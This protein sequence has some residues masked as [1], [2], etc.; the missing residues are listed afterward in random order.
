MDDN[1]PNNPPAFPTRTSGEDPARPDL[2]GMELRDYFAAKALNGTADMGVNHEDETA[3]R[4]YKIA[5]AMLKER[6]K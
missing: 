2:S 4:A 1:K 5:D 6:E 3:K